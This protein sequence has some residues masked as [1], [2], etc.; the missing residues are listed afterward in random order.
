MGEG[1]EVKTD[2]P[3]DNLPQGEQMP[4]NDG[5]KVF[6]QTR[7]I[8]FNPENKTQP[9]SMLITSDATYGPRQNQT[10]L[11][12]DINPRNS[13]NDSTTAAKA[14]AKEMKE[15]LEDLVKQQHAN[16]KYPHLKLPTKNGDYIGP[17]DIFDDLG[18]QPTSSTTSTAAVKSKASSEY[19]SMNEM[20]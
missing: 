13:A 8:S 11:Q 7:K 15:S 3:Q 9:S 1:S 6:H 20:E 19:S 17:L 16:S 5:S 10:K 4:S 14:D 12:I 18:S 2:V